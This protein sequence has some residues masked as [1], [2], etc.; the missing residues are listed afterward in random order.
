LIHFRGIHWKDINGNIDKANAEVELVDIWHFILSHIIAT[1]SLSKPNINRYVCI[2]N[3][4]KKADINKKLC[5]DTIIEKAEDLQKATFQTSGALEV[6]EIFINLCNEFGLTFDELQKLYIGKNALNE[7]RQL[8][9]YKDGTYIKI[10]NGKEDNIIMQEI[11]QEQKHIDYDEIIK[12][13]D[14]KYLKIR[15]K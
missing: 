14:S 11:L 9:G 1:N 10:W 15:E 4:M 6:F 7:F 2:I 12:L 5:V 8:N 3:G 13:L